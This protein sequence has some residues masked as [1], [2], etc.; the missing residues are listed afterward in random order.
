MV[1][2]K[3]GRGKGRNWAQQPFSRRRIKAFWFSQVYKTVEGLP[4]KRNNAQIC[5]KWNESIQVDYGIRGAEHLTTGL[6]R[7]SA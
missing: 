5:A 2:R 3:S 4:H 1:R 6:K 7:A